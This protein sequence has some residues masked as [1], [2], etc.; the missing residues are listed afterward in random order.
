MLLGF[1][2]PVLK[3]CSAVW[4]SAADTLNYW[5]L[6]SVVPSSY[7]GVCLSVTLLIIDLWQSF[8][9][10]I[11]SGVTQRILLVVLYLDRMCQ[12]RLHV[13]LLSHI[14]TLMHCLAAEHRSTSG[15]LF[16]SWCPSGMIFLT[17][18]LIVWDWHVSRAGPMLF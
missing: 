3:F 13:V 8:V 1:V 4:C 16:P 6:L 7:L 11:R 17:P 2:L 12:Y 10:F 14:A 9:C 15:L 5:T 18:S